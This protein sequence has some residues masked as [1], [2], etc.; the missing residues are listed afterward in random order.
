MHVYDIAKQLPFTVEI[1]ELEYLSL[2]GKY[3][4]SPKD[5][6]NQIRQTVRKASNVASLCL[7]SVRHNSDDLEPVDDALFESCNK[8]FTLS[9]EI[10]QLEKLLAHIEEMEGKS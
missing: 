8:L 4:Q 5:A 10:R 1:W 7:F 2:V 3:K 9:E 6:I